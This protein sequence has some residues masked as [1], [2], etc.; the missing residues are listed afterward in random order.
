MS[1]TYKAPVFQHRQ[2]AEIADAFA[3]ER[4]ATTDPIALKALTELEVRLIGKFQCDNGKFDATRFRAAAAGSP[5][6]NKDKR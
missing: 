1:R 6:T 4:S 3:R 2:Y 5:M